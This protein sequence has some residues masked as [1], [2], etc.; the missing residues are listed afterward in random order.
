MKLRIFAFTMAMALGATGCSSGK[1][2]SKGNFKSAIQAY[3][4]STPG[5]CISLPGKDMPYRVEKSGGFFRDQMDRAD[6]L[7]EAGLLTKRDAEVPF[8]ANATKMVPGFE[9]ELTDE[10]RKQLVKGAAGNIGK[11][12]GFCAGK[13]EVLEVVNFTEPADAFGTKISR[14]NYTYKVV[15]PAAWTSLPRIQAAFPQLAKDLK[16][17]ASDKAVLISTN[18]GWMHERLFKA[19]GG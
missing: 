16:D 12:D 15:K 17:D 3:L 18:E 10:G 2:A 1:D 7:V 14:A 19:K 11:W 4:D 13:Y 8:V 6:A 5:A 9:Y